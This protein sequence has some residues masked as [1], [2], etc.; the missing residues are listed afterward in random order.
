MTE[1]DN[2]AFTDCF[3]PEVVQRRCSLCLE[4]S[5]D[6]ANNLPLCSIC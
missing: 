6:S 3:D 4:T 2:S 5:T 1:F